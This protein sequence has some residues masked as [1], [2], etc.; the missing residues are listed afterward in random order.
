MRKHV[1]SLNDGVENRVSRKFFYSSCRFIVTTYIH[2][3][4]FIFICQAITFSLFYYS[5]TRTYYIDF[6]E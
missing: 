5:K 1:L 2:L 3:P 6:I 4:S